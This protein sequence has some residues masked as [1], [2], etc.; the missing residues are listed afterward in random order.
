M[1]ISTK[2]IVYS[3]VLVALIL[4]VA[5][6]ATANLSL[7]LVAFIAFFGVKECVQALALSWL[8]AMNRPWYDFFV[9]L[10]W[11][12]TLLAATR[13]MLPAMGALAL[14]YAFLLSHL[15]RASVTSFLVLVETK[16]RA[17]CV[18]G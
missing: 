6:E 8:F 1:K 3:M 14:A 4:R 10:L 5:S 15:M 7:L 17:A 9:M 2:W 16:K 11:G 12:L 18:V 13:L